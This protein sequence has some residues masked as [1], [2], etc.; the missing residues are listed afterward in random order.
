MPIL[1]MYGRPARLAPSGQSLY[2]DTQDGGLRQSRSLYD[3]DHSKFLGRA[4]FRAMISDARLIHAQYSLV[5]AAVHQKAAFVCAS[6]WA[7][8]FT[9]ED[10]EFGDKA[11]A[12]LSQALGN[13]STNTGHNFAKTQKFVCRYLDV[14]G[15]AFK[16]FALNR[17]GFPVTQIIEAHRIGSRGNETVVTKGRYKG[18]RIQNGI[19][20]SEDAREIAY[21]FL[22]STPAKDRILPAGSILHCADWTFVSE[23]RPWP[24]IAWG[25]LDFYD[26]KEARGFQK[27]KQKVHSALSVIE[28]TETG[29]NINANPVPGPADQSST[30]AESGLRTE[31]LDAGM[32]RYL[33]AKSGGKIEA[34]ESKTP[35]NEWQDFDSRIVESAMLGMRWRPEM[36]DLSKLKGAGFRGFAK[37]INESIKDRHELVASYAKAEL[38]FKVAAFQRRGDIP[39][40]PEWDKFAFPQ[41]Q[42]FNVDPGH[43]QKLEEAN[44]RMGRTSI[45]R[46]IRKDGNDPN[47]ILAETAD[48]LAERNRIAAERGVDPQELGTLSK[49][50]DAY[51]QPT[52]E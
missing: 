46:L 38:L 8:I 32:F 27:I 52:E 4:K 12:V 25:M 11:L 6:G 37:I 16:V 17:N 18:R 9:G 45:P 21:Q 50:G 26:S 43:T 48:W 49:P 23:N 36:L 20:Y 19:I 7:P 14:D 33:R 30:E 15:G 2:K 29:K 28:T 47:E 34:F 39:E 44:A 13:G 5:S 40:H 42:E 35:S 51:V 10:K 22:G 24:S 31:T 41:P 1:D 3:A